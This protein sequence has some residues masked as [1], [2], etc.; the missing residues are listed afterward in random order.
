MLW[1][2]HESSS[3]WVDSL[4]EEFGISKVL[5]KPLVQRGIDNKNQAEAF[6]KPS[7]K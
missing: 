2:V 6:L 1:K 5:S 4:A 3:A 7:F